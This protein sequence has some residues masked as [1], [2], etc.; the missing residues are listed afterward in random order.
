MGDHSEVICAVTGRL[1]EDD[2][3]EIRNIV[4]VARP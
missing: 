3:I 2:W 1:F 4:I